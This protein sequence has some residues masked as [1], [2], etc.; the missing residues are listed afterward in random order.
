MAFWNR[1][2]HPEPESRSQ[3]VTWVNIGGQRI[4][5]AG[6]GYGGII[7]D[8][9][10]MA[11]N[12]PRVAGDLES[13]VASAQPH[14]VMSAAVLARALVLSQL[15]FQWADRESHELFGN[16]DLAILE[17]P[18]GQ[19]MTL[20][21]FLMQCE[22]QASY[23]GNVFVYRDRTRNRLRILRTDHVEQILVSDADPAD[24]EAAQ[25]VP[26][27]ERKE[28]LTY[29]LDADVAGY[30]YKPHKDFPAQ[31]LFPEDVAH[32]QPE[33]HPLHP[34]LGASWIT[35]TIVELQ[36]DL[37]ADTGVDEYFRNGMGP[38]VMHI[39]AEGV[40]PEEAADWRMLN[41]HEHAGIA[42]GSRNKYVSR[43]HLADV[44]TIGSTLK[45]LELGEYRGKLET[46]M[47]VRSRVP[48]TILG[49]SE[50]MNSSALNSNTYGPTRR[51]WADG[52]FTPYAA[53]LCRALEQ[54]VP[55][56]RPTD[57][58]P[59]GGYLSHDPDRVM[60]LQEDRKDAA[61]II[62]QNGQ[63]MRTLVDGGFTPDSV[64]RA[65]TSGDLAKLEHTGKTSVQLLEPGEGDS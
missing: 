19:T 4:P 22:Y 48:A 31:I 57:R 51:M 49:I 47:A 62:N 7:P 46:R 12:R 28:A 65:V 55:T 63:T 35:S 42:N 23:T 56:P 44:K 52:W 21:L 64:V 24:V 45:D 8:P 2:K 43:D 16:P 13:I 6:G 29:V 38:R 11:A 1:K 25:N 30:R 26:P 5:L 60:F 58:F 36:G 10:P 14:S 3:G 53:G 20:P 40:T 18:G 50:G 39:M 61:E 34:Y 37:Q 27:A 33:P 59:A 9:S 32:W 41:E 54:I 17:N 15:W